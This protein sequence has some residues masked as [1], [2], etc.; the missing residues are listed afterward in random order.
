VIAARDVETEVLGKAGARPWD[1]DAD[2]SRVVFDVAEGR[3]EIIHDERQV[4]GYPAKAAATR[5]RFD[6]AAWH[7]DT[8]EPRSGLYPGQTASGR[9]VASPQG[10]R[11]GS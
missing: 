1:R 3:G 2:D 9:D 4:G 7:L 10:K 5:L 8:M 6:P 11:V